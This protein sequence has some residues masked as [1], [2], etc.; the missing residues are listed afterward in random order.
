VEPPVQKSENTP[1][2]ET[3]LP[4]EKCL[5]NNQIP[6]VKEDTTTANVPKETSPVHL[7]TH[8][9]EHNITATSQISGDASEIQDECLQSLP[10]PPIETAPEIPVELASRSKVPQVVDTG[11][12]EGKLV[13]SKVDMGTNLP[14]WEGRWNLKLASSPC[15]YKGKHSSSF[16]VESPPFLNRYGL[17]SRVLNSVHRRSSQGH[18]ELQTTDKN[19]NIRIMYD[20]YDDKMKNGH[21]INNTCS[22]CPD[23]NLKQELCNVIPDDRLNRGPLYDVGNKLIQ[24]SCSQIRYHSSLNSSQKFVNSNSQK[25][26]TLVR[27]SSV[28]TAQHTSDSVVSSREKDTHDF[29]ADVCKRS[30][31]ANVLCL[32]KLDNIRPN[33]TTE[34]IKCSSVVPQEQFVANRNWSHI[35][36]PSVKC[37]TS[38]NVGNSLYNSPAVSKWKYN[39]HHVEGQL[40]P[41]KRVHLLVPPPPDFLVS[42]GESNQSWNKFLQDLDRILENR[43]EFV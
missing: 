34:Q 11:T 13:A 5:E 33:H 8:Q 27:S 24:P 32:A 42:R 9:D 3:L 38:Q 15:R 6:E 26:K 23:Y 16:C 40:S 21:Y 7:E 19:S 10:L 37:A 2:T 22:K 14:S 35:T 4:E 18:S 25:L 39:G 1:E 17:H 43:A 12:S 29:K 31:S 41:E 30:P 28:T 36:D 20:V